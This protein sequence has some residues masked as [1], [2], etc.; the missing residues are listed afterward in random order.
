MI[1]A[2]LMTA[3]DISTNYKKGKKIKEM[4]LHFGV[5]ANTIYYHL[6]KM[7]VKKNRKSQQKSSK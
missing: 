4:M 2:K 5:S 1:K 3:F 6:K 7:D